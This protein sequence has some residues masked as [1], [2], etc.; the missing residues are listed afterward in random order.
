M[1]AMPDQFAVE[2][3][4]QLLIDDDATVAL[5]RS[6]GLA[7]RAWLHAHEGERALC[8]YLLGELGAG[9]TTF[10]RGVM[11]AFEHRG[12]VKS[13]TYTVVEPYQLGDHA[14]YHFDLYRLADPEELQYLGL[15]D[16]FYQGSAC[17]VE[18]PE[19][20]GDFLP[21]ADVR[22][23]LRYV[24]TGEDRALAQRQATLIAQSSRGA[25]LLGLLA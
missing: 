18:W 7:M 16:Y 17:L 2:P 5:G 13:P 24:F 10:S 8:V 11:R 23:D 3:Y 19:R 6:L 14:I 1:I 25:E 22:L 9:K 15:D 12:A 4:R 20:G 21:S